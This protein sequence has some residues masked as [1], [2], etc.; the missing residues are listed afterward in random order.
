L[1]YRTGEYLIDLNAREIRRDD[2]LID[3]KVFFD[4]S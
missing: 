3:V 2:G 1:R 4:L